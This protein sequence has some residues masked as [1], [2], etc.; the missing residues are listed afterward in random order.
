VDTKQLFDPK[1]DPPILAAIAFPV[2]SF[3]KAAMQHALADSKLNQ[4][5]MFYAY[6]NVLRLCVL[7]DHIDMSWCH[8]AKQSLPD[9]V[10][11]VHKAALHCP[12]QLETSCFTCRSLCKQTA[13]S[14]RL[15]LLVPDG[16][17]LSP[18]S[19]GLDASEGV[20]LTKS[21]EMKLG[22][23]RD[24]VWKSLR[25]IMTRMSFSHNNRNSRLERGFFVS[26][27]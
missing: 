5:A 7:L 10:S 9:P 6:V 8:L 13:H 2:S 17:F 26:S 22:T 15:R 21:A 19:S 14:D 18:S 20:A 12:H 23:C 16:K 3:A 11:G 1:S 24:N 27:S 25:L 4:I